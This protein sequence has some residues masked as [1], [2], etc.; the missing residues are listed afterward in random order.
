MNAK[1][2]KLDTRTQL[3]QAGMT[4]F[5]T[6]GFHGTGIKAILDVVGVPKGSFYNYFES[7]NAFGVATIEYYADCVAERLTRSKANASNQIDNRWA[8]A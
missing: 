5:L 7:K 4:L 6:Q 2:E 8:A 1:N 3:L